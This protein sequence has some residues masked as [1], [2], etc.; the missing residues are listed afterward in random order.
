MASYVFPLEK[1]EENFKWL[2]QKRD[3]KNPN[4]ISHNFSEQE[5]LAEGFFGNHI[6]SDRDGKITIVSKHYQEE[7]YINWIMRN[8]HLPVVNALVENKIRINEEKTPYFYKTSNKKKAL[9]QVHQSAN[10]SFTRMF[11]DCMFHLSKEGEAF[12]S[13]KINLKDAEFIQFTVSRVEVEGF[14]KMLEIIVEKN[15]HNYEISAGA[16]R[17]KSTETLLKDAFRDVDSVS[18]KLPSKIRSRI[19]CALGENTLSPDSL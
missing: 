19:V 14:V 15:D 7:E 6:N 11:E 18:T 5:K 9:A 17:Q 4:N 12:V 8:G 2:D 10:I 16:N 3:E 13:L 1:V